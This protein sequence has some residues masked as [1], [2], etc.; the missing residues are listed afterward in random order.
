MRIEK[1]GGHS[2][3]SNRAHKIKEKVD[4]FAFIAKVTGTKI[5]SQAQVSLI[6]QTIKIYKIYQMMIGNLKA[7][8]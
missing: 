3:G 5:Y 4:V 8:D 7:F 1:D 6:Q 2:G